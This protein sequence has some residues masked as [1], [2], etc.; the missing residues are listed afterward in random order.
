MRAIGTDHDR[1]A[2]GCI[3][4]I[5]PE[6]HH[7]PAI[8]ALHAGDRATLPEF[9][10]RGDRGREDTVIEIVPRDDIAVLRQVGLALVER[11]VLPIGALSRSGR[12]SRA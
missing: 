5:L 2:H 7:H 9:G 12:G 3:G 8:H 11:D 1:R 6:A 4:P 10:T